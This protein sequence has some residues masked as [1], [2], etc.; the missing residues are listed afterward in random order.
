MNSRR[1]A[2]GLALATCLALPASAGAAVLHDQYD[3]AAALVSGPPFVDSTKGGP[4]S[5]DTLAADDFTVPAGKVWSLQR[6]E[7]QG[8]VPGS[9]QPPATSLNLFIFRSAGSVP[10]ATPLHKQLEVADG[11]PTSE[12]ADLTFSPR[13]S[14]GP[15][16]YWVAVQSNVSAANP[17]NFVWTT[18][19]TQNGR[20]AAFRQAPWYGNPTA[21]CQSF[22][23]PRSSCTIIPGFPFGPGNPD[24]VFRVH[25]TESN[26]RAPPPPP[27]ARDSL[28]PRV[29]LS[30][31]RR[32]CVRGSF[33]IRIRVREASLRRVTVFL[34][35]RRIARR[36][37]RS[38]RV[39][40]RAH[41]LRPGRHRLRIVAVDQAG[42]RR[43][44]RR[45][46]RRCGA[47]RARR[48]P[49]LTG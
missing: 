10:Q 18:R 33:R 16:T 19:T 21:N 49:S 15:G 5:P 47:R 41:R 3:D 8:G 9:P 6:V 24:Q 23:S 14:L 11:S 34:D 31:L 48:Q 40:I 27:A 39:R 30:G 35:G 28:A 1:F 37:R 38:F 25:G 36:T 46:F 13:P 32:R 44:T 43:V 45:S 26:L 42:N 2:L 7:A 29:R 20:P 4:F 17:F 22:T 12:D